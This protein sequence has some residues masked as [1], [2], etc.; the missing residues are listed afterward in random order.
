MS[1]RSETIEQVPPGEGAM[2]EAVPK[3]RVL[4]LGRGKGRLTDDVNGRPKVV[5]GG[6]VT[7]DVAEAFKALS[8]KRGDASR[9]LDAALRLHPSVAR[10]LP[11][12]GA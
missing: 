10:L 2:N 5:I 3:K 6:S 8:V 9:L 12:S 4:G 11:G 7:P 1:K